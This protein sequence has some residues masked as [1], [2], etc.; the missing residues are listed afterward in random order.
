MPENELGKYF[1]ATKL[2]MNTKKTI[3][4]IEALKMQLVEIVD[5][6]YSTEIE[7]V[8]L[9]IMSLAVPIINEQGTA[10]ATIS[11]TGVI[12]KFED[13]QDQIIEDL[14]KASQLISKEMF[15]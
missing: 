11:V 10:I 1:E 15:L 2:I 3:T 13:R 8:E 6:G 14:K 7:E 4:D 12:P 9:G 5:K